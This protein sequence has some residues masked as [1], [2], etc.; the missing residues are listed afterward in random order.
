M[1][2][3]AVMMFRDGI[4]N[5]VFDIE[6]VDFHKAVEKAIVRFYSESITGAPSSIKNIVNDEA[7]NSE[8]DHLRH[9]FVDHYFQF[10]LIYINNGKLI[11]TCA[12]KELGKVLNNIDKQVSAVIY[13]KKRAERLATYSE[14]KKEFGD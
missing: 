9:Y 5:N 2:Y 3:M 13:Q 10:Y 14:L 7:L 6:A 1:K 8:D 11:K 12:K 4:Y